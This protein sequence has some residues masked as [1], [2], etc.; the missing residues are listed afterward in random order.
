MTIPKAILVTGGAGFIGANLCRQLVAT[1]RYRVTVLDD[2]STGYES[3]LA[4]V[5]VDLVVGSILDPDLLA[6]VVP[7]GGAVV[8]LAALGSVPRSVADPVASH[9]VNATGTML[10]LEAART[11]SATQVLLAS[12]SSVYGDNDAPAK[13]EGLPTAPR[14][15]YGGSKL[16][17]EGY[18]LAYQRTYGLG[19]LAFRFFN[20]FGPLQAA[21]HAYAAVIPSFTDRALRGEPLVVHG[22]G[23]QSRDFTFVGTVCATLVD[24][25]DRGLTFDGPV[26]LAFGTQVELLEVIALIEAELG[27]PLAVEHVEPRTGDIRHSKADPARLH[28]LFP[29]IV[30]IDIETGVRQTVAWFQS[31]GTGASSA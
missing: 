26:N 18:A 29:A 6:R 23:K 2:L 27:R 17:A 9:Q 5:D 30:P 14:S 31:A 19:V 1:G 15:P 3:N 8:H 4:G 16:A 7:A 11:A 20:V 25:L 28:Q 13:H 24:A 22:D 21:G 10:V 12:S